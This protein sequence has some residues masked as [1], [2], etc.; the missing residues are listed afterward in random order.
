MVVNRRQRGKVQSRQYHAKVSEERRQEARYPT[1]D[2]AEVQ[3]LPSTGQRL[4][5]T[6]ID[7]SKSGLRLE[8]GTMLLKGTRVEIMILPPKLVIFGAV[9]YCRR[10]GVVFHAGVLIEGVVSSEPDNSGHL[11]DDEISL[12]VVGKG[13]TIPEV[14][15]AKDH[16]SKCDACSR[17]MTQTATA[18]RSP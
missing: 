12:Y 11:H 8:L 13:L 1:N 14:L 5:A 9:R 18:L 6:V 4:P 16:L 7:I 17:R 15:R 3:V 2:A 10:S